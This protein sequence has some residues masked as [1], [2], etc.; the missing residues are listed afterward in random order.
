MAEESNSEGANLQ[1]PTDATQIQL[2]TA[3]RWQARWSK[4]VTWVVI[5][6]LWI[7]ILAITFSPLLLIPRK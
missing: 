5:I 6:I 2:T 4:F 3:A 1:E 7:G